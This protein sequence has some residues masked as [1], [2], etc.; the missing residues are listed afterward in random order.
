MKRT[1]LICIGLLSL[2]LTACGDESFDD[3]ETTEAALSA[4]DART[5]GV[6]AE[7]PTMCTIG[8]VDSLPTDGAATRTP[9]RPDEVRVPERERIETSLAVRTEGDRVFLSVRFHNPYR[10]P[11]RGDLFLEREGPDGRVF[12][13]AR[14]YGVAIRGGATV[15]GTVVLRQ[16]DAVGTHVFSAR[17]FQWDGGDK[18]RWVNCR[19]SAVGAIG[20][21]D[22]R[23]CPWPVD[24][25]RGELVTADEVLDAQI[26][27]VPPRGDGR[28]LLACSD[29]DRPAIDTDLRLRTYPRHVDAITEWQNRTRQRWT[30]D[31]YLD[32]ITP[33]HHVKI[34]RRDRA[35]TLG[36]G[37][38]FC[39][40][41]QHRRPRVPGV[42]LVTARALQRDGGADAR[43]VRPGATEITSVCSGDMCEVIRPDQRHARITLAGRS[44]IFLESDFFSE[45]T[46]VTLAYRG[47]RFDI[48]DRVRI[49]Q[50]GSGSRNHIA[51]HFDV[52]N[53]PIGPRTWGLYSIELHPMPPVL[54]GSKTAD[55][56]WI[57][58]N[59]AELRADVTPESAEFDG[60]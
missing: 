60:R 52:N 26:D 28:D 34:L 22:S 15:S 20:E 41:D 42:Y 10:C 55:R 9:T 8:P 43:W 3:I 54:G 59:G 36:P 5:D 37:V 57:F 4:T 2:S 45:F 27:D 30:G 17:A 38:G 56:L 32:V 24:L 33:S 31:L 51:V 58:T 23:A 40:L 39:T 53:L 21:V 19:L 49:R 18:E 47:R 50:D 7:A 12:H 29:A 35:V 14:R 1:I 48:T 25:S 13:V 44:A 6:V 11:W 16:P 46:R